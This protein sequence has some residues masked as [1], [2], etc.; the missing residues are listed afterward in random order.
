M[1]ANASKPFV[2]QLTLEQNQLLLN[3]LKQQDFEI[4][5][6]PFT[7]FQ[8]K[9]KGITCTLYESGKLV[10]QGKEAPAFIEFFLEPEILK[11]F[12]AGYKH[13][14]VDGTPRIGIDESGKGDFFG[15]LCVAGV[16]AEGDIF[17]ELITIGVKDSKLL[18]DAQIMKMAPKIRQLCA[19]Q[20]VRISPLKYNELYS[21]FGN[22]NSLLAWG[23]ATAI[24]NLV[25]QT[26][27]KKV[28]IDQFAAERVVLQ[29]LKKKGLELDL[30]QRHKGEEDLVVASASILAREAF[31]EGLKK[32]SV[33]Y[34]IHLPKGASALVIQAGKEFI[35]KHGEHT[36]SFVAKLHFKTLDSIK[37]SAQNPIT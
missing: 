30:T 12:E 15:P 5:K 32:L 24:E 7:L 28:I 26:G 31:V 11:N 34:D 21:K 33:H 16:F 3:H 27:C 36:L 29:A 22:L 18:T 35:S 9:K 1:N 19:H 14:L 8:A 13:M 2:A 20:I 37:G 23:H 25:K 4:N 10:V 17:K 6:L